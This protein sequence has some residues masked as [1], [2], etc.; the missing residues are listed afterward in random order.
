M[1][2]LI[3][4]SNALL[5]EVVKVVVKPGKIKGSIQVP[6]SKSVSHRALICAALAKGTSKLSNVLECDDTRATIQALKAFGVKVTRTKKGAYTVRGGTSQAP[7]RPINCGESGSTL[8]FLMSVACLSPGKVILTG[9]P[10]LLK[11]PVKDGTHALKQLGA[12]ITDHSGFPPV[13][14]LPSVCGGT[15]FLRGDVSSQFLSGM[16]LAAPCF[17][18]KTSIKL[19]TALESRPY[20]DLTLQVMKEFGVKVDVAGREFVVSPSFYRSRNYVV[21]GDFSSAAFLIAAGV[22]AGKVV[23]RGLNRNSKQA[24]KAIIQILRKM[25]AKLHWAG[26]ALIAQKSSLHA[27]RIDVRDCPD[28]VPV[29]AAVACFAKGTSRIHNAGR[30]RLKE[31]DRLAAITQEL[32]KMGAEITEKKDELLIHGG[33]PL[34]GA[35]IDPHGDHR[36]AMACAVAALRA[37]GKTVIQKSECVKKSYPTFFRDLRALCNQ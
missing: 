21:E 7:R 37:E 35:S 23:V 12:K 25:G 24:D 1:P 26:N 20:V 27:E 22:L 8:R 18:K 15:S 28:L 9:K 17:K 4:A 32:R 34:H 10:G 36:I 6:S 2:F 14:I 31:S 19:V 33:K 11:R 29:L 16:L 3:S 30:L 13:T 5:G